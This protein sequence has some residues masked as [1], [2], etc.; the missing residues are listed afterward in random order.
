[1]PCAAEAP[2]GSAGR[3]EAEDELRRQNSFLRDIFEAIVHP[4]YVI[5]SSD[6]SIVMGNSV[7]TPGNSPHR[8]TCYEHIY[9]R[10]E[11]CGS[12]DCV[13]PLKELRRTKKPLAVEHVHCGSDGNL[14]VFEVHAYPVLDTAGNLTEVIEYF[15]DITH[16]KRMEDQLRRLSRKVIAAQ[17]L[18]RKRIASEL[19]D[20]VVQALSSVK[21]RMGGL[22]EQLFGAGEEQKIIEKA[23]EYLEESIAELRRISKD[24]RPDIL[25]EMGLIAATDN[26]CREFETRTGIVCET[27]Y[28]GVS[29]RLSE[30]SELTLYRIVQ[31]ACANIEKHSGAKTVA[32]SL[33]LTG[34]DII[35]RIQDD[36]AGFHSE[37]PYRGEG[38]EQHWGLINM[39]ERAGHL[40]GTLDIKTAPG[41]G[42]EI[43]ARIPGKTR[44]GE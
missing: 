17:E 16:R 28:R 7:A 24:L 23:E 21:F 19:H 10:S 42:T 12:N 41:K 43:V 34:S 11:P 37:K 38:R 44:G 8:P 39:K 2:P 40:G 5:N 30:E 4:F 31:E 25:D 6:Y 9:G 15:V 1:M 13:C 22:K 20:G 18:E 33:S 27:K 29:K 35:M 3:R 14:K 36:G 32:L 26:F